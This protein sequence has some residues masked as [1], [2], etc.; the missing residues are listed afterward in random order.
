MLLL[1]GLFIVF[2]FTFPFLSYK[3]PLGVAQCHRFCYSNFYV[4]ITNTFSEEWISEN[5]SEDSLILVK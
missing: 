1:Y 3:K 4:I 5:V 2:F